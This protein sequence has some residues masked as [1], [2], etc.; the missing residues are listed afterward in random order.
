MRVL[1]GLLGRKGLAEVQS[2][3]FYLVCLGCWLVGWLANLAWFAWVVG[4]LV[5]W[6][7]WLGLL[8]L[9]VGW[10]AGWLILAWFGLVG[11]FVRAQSGARHW[12]HFEC[13]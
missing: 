10:L 6:L 9:L 12:G 7:I 2:N 4:W 13:L 1:A 8:G 5:G 11:W 3:L